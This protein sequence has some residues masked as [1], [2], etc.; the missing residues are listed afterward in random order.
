MLYMEKDFTNVRISRQLKQ[1][2]VDR[3]SYYESFNDILER[4][5]KTKLEKEH[6]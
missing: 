6:P 4:I 3:G 1:K 2:I 5:L